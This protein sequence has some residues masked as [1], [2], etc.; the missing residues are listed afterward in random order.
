MNHKGQ[1]TTLEERVTIADRVL[2]GQSSREIAE[3]LGRP[4]STVRKWRQRYNR[5]GRS[6]LSSQMGRPAAG[7]L[8][9]SPAE[10]KDAILELRENH[11]GWG[12]Q[13][14]RLE[15]AKDMR[16]TGLVIPSRGRIAAYLKEKKKVR[17][18]ERHRNLPEPKAQPVQR[19][20]QE[21]E[22][23]AQGVTT[24]TGLGKVSVINILDVHSHVSI[25]SHACLN[26]SHPRSEEYQRV[27]RRAFVHYGLPEQI[28]LDHDS[29][30]YDNKSASPFPS[31]IHLWLIALGV[32][33]RF[34]HKRPPLDH[35]RIERHHQTIAGQAVADQTFADVI[36]LQRNLQARMLFL[37]QEYPTSALNGQPPLQ[38]FPQ[39]RHSS[40]IFSPE[41]EEQ[42]LSMQRVYEYLKTG[43]WFRQISSVGMFSLG[44]YRYNASTRFSDQTLEITF[45]PEARTL[46]CLPEKGMVTFRLDVQGLTKSALMGSLSLLPAYANFQLALPFAYPDTTL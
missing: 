35:A 8:A 39:A 30:F 13:T 25:D 9:K 32:Q 34:I 36:E 7:A 26:A 31:V 17:K 40:R 24:V 23:D 4:L 37:N 18:Y 16:F 15:I 38:A 29:A 41:M 14:L 21:W 1:T 10:M 27:L 5:E 11:P 19:P 43:R 45:D 46:I 12:A 20:H 28:S 2:A 22:M 44:S 6:G 33:V 42:S 3:E